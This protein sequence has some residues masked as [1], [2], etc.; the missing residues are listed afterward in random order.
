MKRAR[1]LRNIARDVVVYD[2]KRS[3]FRQLC[4][5]LELTPVEK[6]LVDRLADRIIV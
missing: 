3:E 2:L 1:Q 5:A 4:R 6:Q